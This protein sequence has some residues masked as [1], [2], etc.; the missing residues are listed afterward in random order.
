MKK[1]KKVEKLKKEMMKAE[2]IW[3]KINEL[4]STSVD[5]FHIF[6]NNKLKEIYWKKY[7][8]AEAAYYKE[9]SL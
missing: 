3:E 8:A 7:T 1:M 4:P 6:N 2:E 5:G 9:L